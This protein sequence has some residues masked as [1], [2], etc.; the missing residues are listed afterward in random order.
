MGK[1]FLW[2]ILPYDSHLVIESQS[3]VDIQGTLVDWIYMFGF[4][5]SVLHINKESY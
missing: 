2:V 4:G 1:D 5:D 3:T